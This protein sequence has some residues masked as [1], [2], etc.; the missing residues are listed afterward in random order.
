MCWVLLFLHCVKTVQFNKFVSLRLIFLDFINFISEI[1]WKPVS[2]HS[3]LIFMFRAVYNKSLVRLQ[4][5]R[6]VWLVSP[7]KLSF[8]N[9]NFYGI[10]TMV[11]RRKI[12]GP[13][14][15]EASEG[16][17]NC[18]LRSFNIYIPHQ[19]LLGWLEQGEVDLVMACSVPLH[20]HNCSIYVVFELLSHW[21]VARLGLMSWG[22]KCM[23]I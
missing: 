10:S 16:G 12:I 15:E 9:S 17:E 23:E 8:L 11:M 5:A 22:C 2:L 20:L 21:T 19:I 6:F 7:F 14:R 4:V 18:V 3:L 1:L 13:M